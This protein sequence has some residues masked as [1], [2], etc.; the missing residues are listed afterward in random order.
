MSEA[1]DDPR[2]G[3]FKSSVEEFVKGATFIGDFPESGDSSLLQNII[4]ELENSSRQVFFA[5]DCNVPRNV[6]RAVSDLMKDVAKA[7][8]DLLSE[9]KY[10]DESSE[11]PIEEYP[12]DLADRADDLVRVDCEDAIVV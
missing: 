10:K 3:S 8:Y 1:I 5:L 12:R 11:T 2:C 4:F 6:A 9:L 7:E